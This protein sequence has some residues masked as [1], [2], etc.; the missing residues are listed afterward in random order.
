LLREILNRHPRIFCGP[1]TSMFGLPFW[2]PNIAS[3][4]EIDEAELR[5]EVS[6]S[7]NLIRFAERFYRRQAIEA[8]KIRWAD[9]TPNNIR[10]IEKILTWFP[11]GKFIHIIRDGR[12]VVCSLRNHPKEK[13]VNGV[14]VP[15]NNNN[16]IPVCANRWLNDTAKGLSFRGHPRYME[17]RYEDL[18]A[19][20]ESEIQRI[21]N[22]VGEEYNSSMLDIRNVAGKT[23]KRG[24]LIN[25]ANAAQ[26]ITPR[27]VGRWRK[28]LTRTEKQQFIDLAGEFLIVAGYVNNHIWLKDD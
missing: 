10:S 6:N 3:F 11:K 24:R 5:L 26:R 18:V 20:P 22:F 13:F 25:N 8:G 16:P 7:V 14:L 2:P 28:D 12:D 27:S 15:L 17:I 19:N 21:C 1:E 9:K 4:W 23:M